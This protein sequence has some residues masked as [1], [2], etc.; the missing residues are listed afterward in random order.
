MAIVPASELK[1][2]LVVGG[3]PPPSTVTA[4][5]AALMRMLPGEVGMPRRMLMPT[6]TGIDR[7]GK[8]RRF[9]KAKEPVLADAQQMGFEVI[10]A[11]LADL[12]LDTAGRLLAADVPIDIVMLQWD[13]IRIVDDGGGLAAL[14]SADGAGTVELVGRTESALISSKTVL[15]WLHEDCEAGLLTPADSDLVRAH[16]SWTACLGLDTDP[17]V[18]EKKLRITTSERARLVAKPAIGRSGSGVRFGSQTS[19]QDWLSV[20]VDASPESPMVLQQRVQSDRIT[21]P[22]RDLESGELV[23]A[24]VP[25]VSAR[26]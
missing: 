7:K 4:R 15:A 21:M 25:S 16:V 13:S 3:S 2:A 12:R 17:A 19:E 14:Q 11:D 23:T 8:L 24:Q 10:Q 9:G 20:L 1:T 6:C 26:S 22:F 5:S 18:H